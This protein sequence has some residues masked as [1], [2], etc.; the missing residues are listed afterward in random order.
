MKVRLI[1]SPDKPM[2]KKVQIKYEHFGDILVDKEISLSKSRIWSLLQLP[3][4]EQQ[5]QAIVISVQPVDAHGNYL[6]IEELAI[7]IEKAE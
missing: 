1:K 5:E 4:T 2:K 6:R 3:A 7:A